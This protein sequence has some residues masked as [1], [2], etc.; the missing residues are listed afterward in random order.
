M[1]PVRIGALVLLLTLALTGCELTQRI[2]EGAYRNAVADGA[3]AE[4][5]ERGV[6]MDRRP[7]CLTPETGSDAVVRIRCTGRSSTG[8]GVEV[9][10]G[11]DRADT[12]HPRES[13]VIKVD[14]REI[15][16]TSCLG[17]SCHD[18]S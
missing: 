13:Y 11:A 9:T 5:A 17:V 6:R 15:L 3:R 2:S 10:G 7:A 4:L 18:S 12:G 16:R 14:G 1:R 8:A